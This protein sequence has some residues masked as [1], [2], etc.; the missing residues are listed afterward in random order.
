MNG[1]NS[2]FED[3]FAVGRASGGK[4]PYLDL[5]KL[6]RYLYRVTFGS[7]PEYEELGTPAALCSS[8]VADGRLHRNLDW[9]YNEG[10]SFIVNLPGITGMAFIDGLTADNM[11]ESLIAQLPYHL[12]D[13][14]N[15]HGIMVS[16]H[17]LYN[18]WEAHGTGET[19]LTVL[20]L[21]VLQR[22][23]SMA[24]LETELEGILDDL[25]E[26][27]A[28]Q[29]AELLIQVLVTDGTTTCV[30]S[31]KTDGSGAYEIIDIT[32]NPKLTNFR[33]VA[34]ETVERGE[35][36]TRPTGVERWNMIPCE[37]SQLRFT[38]AY[39]APDRLSEFIGIDGTDKDSTDEELEEIYDTAHAEYLVRE[40]DGSLWQT[41]HSVI[42]SGTGMKNLWIQEDW[43]HDY[44]GNIVPRYGLY[45]DGE[46]MLLPEGWVTVDGDK[47]LI[48]EEH[49]SV[50]DDKLFIDGGMLVPLTVTENGTYVPIDG[51]G[52]SPVIVQ[53][54][55][56]GG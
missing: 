49:M 27:A 38:K 5:E 22:V 44:C 3:G 40:R 24:A 41:M 9:K 55:N 17:V 56:G 29:A 26:S 2:G 37:L 51:E 4:K 1:Y 47:L 33:W 18:D 52:F 14:A 46:L 12:V 10:V 25:H 53:I 7:L 30:L 34:D 36:Q 39:E 54:T 23:T 50:S 35:L 32:E 42:Y 28:M 8:Y 43:T 19:P 6:N 45:F 15:S 48:D 21:T 11:D 31:P 13:G 20:P 16:T